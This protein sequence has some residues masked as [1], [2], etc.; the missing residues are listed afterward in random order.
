MSSNELQHLVKMA[1]QIA[2]NISSETDSDIVAE[3]MANH[4]RLFWSPIMRDKL[5]TYMQA[6][7]NE[8]LPVS[9]KALSLLQASAQ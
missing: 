7:P 6:Q 2:S 9:Q 3:K 4:I 1:N 5:L 8:L